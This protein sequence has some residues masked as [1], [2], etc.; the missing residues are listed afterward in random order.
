[1]GGCG[2][3]NGFPQGF[4]PRTTTSIVVSTGIDNEKFLSKQELQQDQE[5]GEDQE[6]G[7]YHDNAV[8]Y[9]AG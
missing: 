6:R 8:G 4:V 1:M 7:G 9:P 2:R 3:G 5:A